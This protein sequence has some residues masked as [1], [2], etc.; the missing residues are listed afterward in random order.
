MYHIVKHYFPKPEWLVALDVAL[1]RHDKYNFVR[2]LKAKGQ[3]K[4]WLPVLKL[5]RELYGDNISKATVVANLLYYQKTDNIFGWVHR[6][7]YTIVKQGLLSHFEDAYEDGSWKRYLSSRELHLFPGTFAELVEAEEK[8]L[9]EVDVLGIQR[10]E[11]EDIEESEEESEQLESGEE[12][13]SE[14]RAEREEGVAKWGESGGGEEDQ[15]DESEGGGEEEDESAG[16]SNKSGQT[17]SSDQQGVSSAGSGGDS[18][19]E[20]EKLI[21][22]PHSSPAV[23][24]TVKEIVRTMRGREAG[25]DTSEADEV[26]EALKRIVE[27]KAS[28]ADFGAVERYLKGLHEVKKVRENALRKVEDALK[29]KLQEVQLDSSTLRGSK[30][31]GNTGEA[32]LLVKIDEAEMCKSILEE[33]IR[34]TKSNLLAIVKQKLRAVWHRRDRRISS[35]FLPGQ[36]PKHDKRVRIVVG[37][38]VSGS[39]SARELKLFTSV[40]LSELKRHKEYID[41]QNSYAVFWST[42]VEKAVSLVEEEELTKVPSGGG[43][44]PEVFW[45]WLE[46]RERE[47]KRKPD[48]ILF[49]SDG[50][51]EWHDGLW[52]A[53][54]EH[55]GV[56]VVTENRE[57]AGRIRE[58]GW[59]VYEGSLLECSQL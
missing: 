43:T 17:A 20:Y 58:A 29:K 54:R 59:D 40:L 35:A 10:P 36:L 25:E 41:L 51:F 4:Y 24:M 26:A 49:L 32:G 27:R 15:S 56:A 48:I 18:S 2:V 8:R 5:V 30:S 9:L 12:E 42:A 44:A 37:V 39:I 52:R 34:K 11:E 28:L 31:Q 21:S 23:P 33:A 1:I 3:A 14:G 47:W 53:F 50:W 46:E 55:R 7:P 13:Q 57:V 38:D 45:T 6:S 16:T 19:S 22:R